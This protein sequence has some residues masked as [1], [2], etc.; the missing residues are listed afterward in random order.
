MESLELQFRFVHG[1][2][3][4][5]L[6]GVLEDVP[7]TEAQEVV[8][9]GQPVPHIHG[10]AVERLDLG[11]FQIGHDDVFPQALGGPDAELRVALGFHPVADGNDD[12]EIVVGGLVDFSI[13]GSPCKICTY[14]VLRQ[15]ALLENV[16]FL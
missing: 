15:F 9:L 3:V 5:N 7:S 11:E 12:I 10:L 14:C 4:G 16:T 1:L 2:L 8:Q 13:I 6:P